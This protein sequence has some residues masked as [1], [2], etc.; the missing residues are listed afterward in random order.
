MSDEKR[1]YRMTRRAELQEETR[2]RIT[3]SAV[4]LHERLGPSRTSMAAVAELAGVERSTLYRHFPDEEALFAACSA[5]WNAQHVRPDLERWLEIGDPAERLLEGLTELYAW[6]RSTGTML[7]RLIRDEH[8]VP[9]V[10]ERFGAFHRNL[11]RA[12][13]VLLAGRGLRGR[14][15]TTVDAVLRVALA[16]ETWRALCRE[17]DLDDR[18]AAERMADLVAAAAAR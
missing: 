11:D 14:R 13:E 10:A 1:I 7:D 2:R 15:R 8:L 9:A 17:G 4:E 12:R 3:E 18:D 16:F 5:H 6:Y